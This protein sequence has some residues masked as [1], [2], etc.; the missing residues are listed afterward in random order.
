MTWQYPLVIIMNSFTNT[1]VAKSTHKPILQ[2]FRANVPA[3]G[4][5][6]SHNDVFVSVMIFIS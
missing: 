6:Y 3:S 5:M 2:L 4:S 1:V